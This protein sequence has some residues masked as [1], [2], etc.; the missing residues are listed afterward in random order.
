MSYEI[1][2]GIAGRSMI[3]HT[4]GAGTADDPAMLKNLAESIDI[5]GQREAQ[6]P[7]GETITVSPFGMVNVRFSDG[8]L[9]TM[10]SD[11][12]IKAP[13][14]TGDGAATISG[15]MLQVSSAATG[16]ASVFSRRFVRY[17]QGRGWYMRLTAGF[18]GTGFGYAASHYDQHGFTLKYN[19]GSL[20]FLYLKGSVETGETAIPA[21]VLSK[22]GVDISKPNIW[23]MMGAYLGVASPVLM[24][25]HNGRLHYVSKLETEGHISGT[26]VN[27][28]V[29]RMGVKA[30]NGCTVKT[31]SWDGGVFIGPRESGTYRIPKAWPTQVGLTTGSS[32]GEVSLAANSRVVLAVFKNTSD[33]EEARLTSYNFIVTP[34]ANGEGV[35]S[36]Q[37][38]YNPT[39]SGTP[40]YVSGPGCM[41]V[42]HTAGVGAQTSAPANITYVSGGT[43]VITQVVE[44]VKGGVAALPPTDTD[45]FGL[46]A[47]PG[48]DPYAIIITNNGT[49]A[50]KVHFNC[51]FANIR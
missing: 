7:F 41:S 19:N 9:T 11:G 12:L 50:V 37:I 6:S 3:V 44:Y 47:I 18:T 25:R 22:I 40:N 46:E 49:G 33:L 16:S 31:G 27:N 30:V 28:P 34:P 23:Y 32:Q 29:F 13:V 24:V 51:T 15:S 42:C 2:S 43:V 17:Q 38:V 45:A 39:L 10:Q 14:L 20:S 1:L 36:C 4:E 48:D 35:C 21:A 5:C 26:H 8:D